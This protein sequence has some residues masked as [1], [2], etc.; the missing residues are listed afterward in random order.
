MEL[1]L[2]QVEEF[3]RDLSAR[4]ERLIRREGELVQHVARMQEGLSRQEAA[5]QMRAP[6]V[7]PVEESDAVAFEDAS[8]R[9]KRPMAPRGLRIQPAG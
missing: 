8:D 5:A 2:G 4:E 1:Y 7:A 3:E 6:G 9:R